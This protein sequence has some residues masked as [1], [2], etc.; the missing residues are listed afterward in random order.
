MRIL[1]ISPKELMS[2]PMESTTGQQNITN[3]A[4][5]RIASHQT[6][7]IFIKPNDPISDEDTTTTKKNK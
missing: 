1:L 6:G 2:D 5:A 4:N 7:D 3:D